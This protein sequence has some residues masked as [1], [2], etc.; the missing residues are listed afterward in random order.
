MRFPQPR[1]LRR[2][3][4][5]P[6]ARMGERGHLTPAQRRPQL[7]ELQSSLACPG[8]H[9]ATSSHYSGTDQGPRAMRRGSNPL[10]PGLR[11]RKF[12]CKCQA[13]HRHRASHQG[14]KCKFLWRG[15]GSSQ[16]RDTDRGLE[17]EPP[18]HTSRVRGEP[19][20]SRC[21]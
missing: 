2:G 20:V 1:D 6:T 11:M 13:D 5:F 7:R 3:G 16:G 15:K 9:W 4:H 14:D 18:T 10:P 8:T 12:P 17:K 19:R 21:G